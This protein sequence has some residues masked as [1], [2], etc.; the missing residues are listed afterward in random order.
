MVLTSSSQRAG[1]DSEQG[2]KKQFLQGMAE[3]TGTFNL[4]KKKKKRE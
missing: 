3:Q 2:D 4:K 1:A